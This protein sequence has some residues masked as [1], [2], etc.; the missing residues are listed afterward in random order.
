MHTGYHLVVTRKL[1]A[2]ITA[3]GYAVTSYAPNA[4]VGTQTVVRAEYLI[5]VLYYQELGV[6]SDSNDLVPV[7]TLPQTHQRAMIM[8]VTE[9]PLAAKQ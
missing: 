7:S 6:I 2:I 8:H 9:E 1:R 3:Q 4:F 5:P